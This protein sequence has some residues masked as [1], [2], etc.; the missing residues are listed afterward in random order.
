MYE[1]TYI[2][3]GWD[4]LP[5]SEQ[6][7][8]VAAFIEVQIEINRR[9]LRA[10]PRTK[11]IYNSGVRYKQDPISCTVLNPQYGKRERAC[12]EFVDI[13]TMLERGFADCKSLTA[14]R[15]AELRESGDNAQIAIERISIPAQD[16]I[17][18]HI[19]LQHAN[20]NDEDP[21]VRLGMKP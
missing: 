12:E 17:L 7:K 14:W 2:V 10:N 11:L 19:T 16:V 9:Y 6:K 1:A 21:S 5:Q 3:G 15:I 8:L 4:A 18:Y 20:G 13:P